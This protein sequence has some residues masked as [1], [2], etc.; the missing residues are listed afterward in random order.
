MSDTAATPEADSE[1]EKDLTTQPEAPQ[2]EP[3]KKRGRPSKED[4]EKAEAEREA[5]EWEY[6]Y[7]RELIEDSEGRLPRDKGYVVSEVTRECRRRIAE[8]NEIVEF[9]RALQHYVQTTH[10][11]QKP[12]VDGR[13]ASKMSAKNRRKLKEADLDRQKQIRATLQEMG[14]IPGGKK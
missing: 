13:H 9:Q 12:K 11:S 2:E 14:L 4:K 8:A 6:D 5:A 10:Q 3:K 7:P 1:D